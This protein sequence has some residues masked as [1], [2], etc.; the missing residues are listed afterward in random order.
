MLGSRLV[1]A[2]EDI[3]RCFDPDN[4]LNP[5]KIV[6][7]PRMDDRSLLRARFDPDTRR[8]PTALD[9]S[10]WGGFAGAVDMCNNNG[11]CRKRDAGVMCPS[12][13]ATSGTQREVAQTRSALPS[14][15][16]SATIPGIRRSC[17]T[18]WTSA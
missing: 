1:S 3:K 16:N 17:M 18:P 5:G 11:A 9:W 12:F 13:R 14:R 10:A 7:P 4:R 2:F 6:D 8:L 15:D